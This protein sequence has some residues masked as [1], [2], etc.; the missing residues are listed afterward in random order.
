MA[1]AERQDLVDLLG[2]L[3]PEQWEQSSLCAGWRVRDVVG[4]IIGY[5]E[6]TAAETVREFVR[7][8]FFPPRINAA[9]LARHR[10]RDTDELLGVFAAHLVPRGL[11][12]GFGGR[13]ALSDSLIH[14]QD[15]RRSLGLPR[16]IPHDR[17]RAVLNFARYVPMLR[18]AW[19]ARGARLVATDLDWSFGHGPQVWGTGEALLMTMVGRSSAISDLAGPGVERLAR[20]LRLPAA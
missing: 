12:T 19:R 16:D 6:L 7:G 4:H 11:T 10:D 14:H 3:T 15:I 20:N 8:G 17:L 18:G 9:V 5:D 1:T 2:E 13:I